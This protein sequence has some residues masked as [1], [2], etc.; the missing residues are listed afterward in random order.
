MT[1]RGN[2]STHFFLF[3]GSQPPP[4]RGISF[5]RKEGERR[6]PYSKVFSPIVISSEREK[7][8]SFAVKK[9]WEESGKRETP[10][11]MRL[12]LPVLPLG[13]FTK[14]NGNG[15][16]KRS[17]GCA[18]DDETR[19]RFYPFFYSAAANL[20]PFGAPPSEGRRE[21]HIPAPK[22]T[23]VRREAIRECRFPPCCHFERTREIFFVRGQG[24]ARGKRITGNT[25][26]HATWDHGASCGQTQETTKGKIFLGRAEATAPVTPIACIAAIS[27]NKKIWTETRQTA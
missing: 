17:L 12:G 1:K 19:K 26:L 14:E 4:L 24:E 9:K 7:S 18:R 10:Y 13:S 11:C 22:P 5:Q 23:S 25:V 8:F 16:R 3:R 20:R 6:I 15:K 27:Y 2:A 21:R